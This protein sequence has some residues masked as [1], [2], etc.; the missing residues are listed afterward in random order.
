MCLY[1][2]LENFTPVSGN[3][4]YSKGVPSLE[5]GKTEYLK[6]GISEVSGLVGSNQ[7]KNNY[8]IQPKPRNLLLFLTCQQLGVENPIIKKRKD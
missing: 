7:N 3:L 4:E 8:Y 5:Y 6:V 2:N 1:G